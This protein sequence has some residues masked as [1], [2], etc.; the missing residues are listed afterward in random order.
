MRIYPKNTTTWQWILNNQPLGFHVVVHWTGMQGGKK[1]PEKNGFF[2]VF[3][4]FFPASLK[5]EEKTEK[6]S[7]CK[8]SFLGMFPNFSWQKVGTNFCERKNF[9]SKIFWYLKNLLFVILVRKNCILGFN[10]INDE[11]W[12]QK[13]DEK[14]EYLAKIVSFLRIIFALFYGKIR[15][16]RKNTGKKTVF[17]RP[18]IFF[19]KNHPCTKP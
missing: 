15:K 10:Y 2:F 13:I 8:T 19:R 14:R 12:C 17:F 4:W 16:K 5:K 6:Y 7:T 9:R 1:P 3:Y 11:L 18:I